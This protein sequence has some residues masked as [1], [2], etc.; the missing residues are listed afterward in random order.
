M[1]HRSAESWYNGTE[2]GDF[3]PENDGDVPRKHEILVHHF[4]TGKA[5]EKSS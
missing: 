3:E 5:V 4:F 1:Y 2:N